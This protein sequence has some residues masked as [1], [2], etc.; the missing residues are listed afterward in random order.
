[1]E[2]ANAA[3]WILPTPRAVRGLRD[4]VVDADASSLSSLAREAVDLTTPPRLWVSDAGSSGIILGGHPPEA[5]GPGSPWDL[6]S[7]EAVQGFSAAHSP[8]AR[9]HGSPAELPVPEAFW[10]PTASGHARALASPVYPC[11]S[12]GPEPKPAILRWRRGALQRPP[13]RT[14]KRRRAAPSGTVS[15]KSFKAINGAMQKRR[16]EKHARAQAKAEAR[17]AAKAAAEAAKEA[18]AQARATAKAAAAAAKPAQAEARANREKPQTRWGRCFVCQRALRPRLS[19][20]GEAF[21]LCPNFRYDAGG[22]NRI[23]LTQQDVVAMHFPR[24]YSRRTRIAY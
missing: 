22:H 6:R 12:V 2:S 10:T 4:F 19:V 5:R 21:L 24:L 13:G 15:P 9:G 16:D 20:R 8:E 11:A 23:C 17:A 1:M 18:K 7:P 3:P 14:P